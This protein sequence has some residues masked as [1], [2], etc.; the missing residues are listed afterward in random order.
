M[1]FDFDRI[2]DCIEEGEVSLYAQLSDYDR[3]VVAFEEKDLRRL[4]KDQ[5]YPG[6]FRS[7]ILKFHIKGRPY[8]VVYTGVEGPY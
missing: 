3:E 2:P 7:R 4:H 5:G 1:G 6:R 8:W